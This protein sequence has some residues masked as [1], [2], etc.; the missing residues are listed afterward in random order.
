MASSGSA[1]AGAHDAVEKGRRNFSK[2]YTQVLLTD[3]YGGYNGVVVGNAIK[4][5]L[6]IP[7][8]TKVRGSERLAPE[9]AREA[10][11]LIDALFAVERQAKDISASKPSK[12]RGLVEPHLLSL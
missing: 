3:A 2:D 12:A 11:A 7:C 4:R 1:G 10:V 8:E 9:I 6:L 5:R